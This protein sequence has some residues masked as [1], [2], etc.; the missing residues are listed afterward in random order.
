MRF[1]R[2]VLSGGWYL[3]RQA[4]HPSKGFE[5]FGIEMGV[6][7]VLSYDGKSLLRERHSSYHKIYRIIAYEYKPICKWVIVEN[8]NYQPKIGNYVLNSPV[9]D[10]T[11]ERYHRIIS[12]LFTVDRQDVAT[13]R[14]QMKNN[15]LEPCVLS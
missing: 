14:L 3:L 10:P 15:F 9:Y 4:T 13:S 6:H 8:I 12:D 7:I 5:L 11:C 1:A 2:Y